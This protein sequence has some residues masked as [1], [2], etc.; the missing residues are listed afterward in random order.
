MKANPPATNVYWQ[1]IKSGMTT[2]ITSNTNSNR[3]GG[4]VV[5]KPSLEIFS[6]VEDD[7]ATYVCFAK[8]NVG[9]GQS[10]Q[11]TLSVNGSMFNFK[12]GLPQS[13]I[14]FRKMNIHLH[15]IFC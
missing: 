8:N 14:P 9:T 11:I 4:S 1:K 6:V 7:A 2:T 3:Y 13:L 5:Q 15:V 10:S 12:L